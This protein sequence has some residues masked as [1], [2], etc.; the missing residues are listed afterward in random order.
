[1]YSHPCMDCGKIIHSS[2]HKRCWDCWKKCTPRNHCID[3]GKEI[4]G[5]NSK[6][7]CLCY[8]KTRPRDGFDKG[9]HMLN[10]NGNRI[11]EHRL[12]MEKFIGRKLLPSEIVHHKNGDRL[13]NRI[14]NLELMTQRKHASIHHK[15]KK[16]RP[17][18]IETRKKI[19]E[20]IK[21]FWSGDS[22]RVEEAR[23][24]M[25]NT[26]TGNHKSEESKK[27]MSE[28]MKI[29]HARNPKRHSEETRKKMSDARKK[30]LAIHRN[31]LIE[32]P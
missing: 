17:T 15:G 12:I 24:K 30:Y 8:N 16:P 28:S 9:Y 3:C 13:D 5:K 25:I 11:R 27:K 22:P 21:E 29:A 19:S 10:I 6:R 18:T 26:H 31:N 32:I 1:M 20:S 2:E 23:Q 7:C 14:D 4:V